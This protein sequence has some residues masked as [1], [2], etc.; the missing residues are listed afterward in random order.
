MSSGGGGDGGCGF[1]AVISAARAIDPNDVTAKLNAAPMQAAANF[2]ESMTLPLCYPCCPIQQPA[3]VRRHAK[4]SYRAAL[5]GP[6][7]RVDHRHDRCW[8]D[9]I[10]PRLRP[11]PSQAMCQSPRARRGCRKSVT[12]TGKGGRFHQLKERRKFGRRELED[13]HNRKYLED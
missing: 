13:R 9:A 10:V 3:L 7:S 6:Q 2:L 4:C 12:S 8:I 11:H 1:H 5:R